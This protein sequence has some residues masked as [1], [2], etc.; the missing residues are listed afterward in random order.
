MTIIKR[1][2]KLT[3]DWN[4]MIWIDLSN[5]EIRNMCVYGAS[6]SASQNK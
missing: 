5:L 1:S 6:L 4:C 3:N 2:N